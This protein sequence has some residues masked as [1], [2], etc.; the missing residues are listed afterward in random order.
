MLTPQ[1]G[2]PHSYLAAKGYGRH[3]FN[4]HLTLQLRGSSRHRLALALSLAMSASIFANSSLILALS[5]SCLPLVASL[6]LAGLA[7]FSAA[8][9]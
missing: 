3:V 9:A 4:Q 1:P 6:L 5:N 8:R 2:P 7:G